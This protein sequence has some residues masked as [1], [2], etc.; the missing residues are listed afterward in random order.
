MTRLFGELTDPEADPADAIPL[1]GKVPV[2]Q[3]QDM[4]QL[5]KHR[6]LCSDA[7]GANSYTTI[8]AGEYAATVLTDPPYNVRIASVQG[9][10]KIKHPNF[11]QASGEMSRPEFTAFLGESLGHAAD[12]S[13]DG[14]V[15]Y[16]FMDW[17][18]MA[19]LL[20]AGAVTYSELK[21]LVVWAKPTQAW[22]HSTGHSTSLCSSLRS[23][24]QTTSTTLPWASMGARDRT[25]GPMPA[26]IR[27]GPAVRRTSKRTRPS[28]R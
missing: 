13:M 7:R 27:F 18:H 22:G 26:Q 24:L 1:I 12:H 20:E 6:L 16:I 4:W 23:E 9:R 25:S 10:G 15:H 8:M 5:G 17:R 19:E 28:S 3:Q 21:M 2:T 14:A 11:A